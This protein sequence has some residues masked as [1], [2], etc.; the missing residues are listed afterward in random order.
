MRGVLDLGQ[1]LAWWSNSDLSAYSDAKVISVADASGYETEG[2][3]P[4]GDPQEP[5]PLLDLAGRG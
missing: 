3:Q 2:K 1:R 4:E 5:P